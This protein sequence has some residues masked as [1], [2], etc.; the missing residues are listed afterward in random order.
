MIMDE[1]E[2]KDWMSSL[3]I[4]NNDRIEWERDSDGNYI[5]VQII[6]GDQVADIQDTLKDRQSTYG[7]PNEHFART[8]ALLNAAGFRRFNTGTKLF[9]ELTIEDWPQIMIYDKLARAANDPRFL[10][11]PHDIA[12]YGECWKTLITGEKID[13]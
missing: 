9:E 5:N 12:G 7:P 13:G 10:D 1:V 2:F 6:R 11:N 4:H 8:V 3:T